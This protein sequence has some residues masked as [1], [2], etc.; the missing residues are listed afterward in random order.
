MDPAH[1]QMPIKPVASAGTAIESVL[2]RV[3]QR[4][5]AIASSA[6]AMNMPQTLTTDVTLIVGGSSALRV[7]VKGGCE[8]Q[9][10]PNK[11]LQCSSHRQM[12]VASFD[13]ALPLQLVCQPLHR[14]QLP[15][16][17]C[18]ALAAAAAPCFSNAAAWAWLPA[19]RSRAA[20][21]SKAGA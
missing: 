17:R 15:L 19:W 11:N 14:F 10:N 8:E 4:M 3:L 13:Q 18:T 6:P 16:A 12:L 7:L 20:H 5:S 9:R 21:A 1:A 2:R